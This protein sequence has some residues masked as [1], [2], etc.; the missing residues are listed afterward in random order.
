[1]TSIAKKD[2]KK[3]FGLDDRKP[4]YFFSS[5]NQLEKAA[6]KAPQIHALRRAFEQLEIN[7]V[8][9]QDRVGPF[10]GLQPVIYFRQVDNIDPNSIL[11]LHR[12]FW[13]QGIAPI[14]VVI[15]PNDVHIY[16]GLL[17]PT[18]TLIQ[19]RRSPGLVETLERV[20]DQLRSFLLSV[21]SGEY[22]HIHRHSFDPRQRVDRDL[23]HNLRVTRQALGQIQPV[24]LASPT[25][26]TLLCRLVFTCYL[27]DRG[28]IDEAYL[29]T[30]DIQDADHLRDILARKPR[31]EAKA[32]LYRLF[33]QLASDFNGDLF[34]A[35]LEEE[36]R[37]IRVEHLE[38]LDQFFHGAK[39]RSG[40][41]AFWP[42]DF[43]FIP[44]ETISAIYEHFLKAAGKE[45]KKETGAF[46]TPR[47][48][49]EFVLD[50]ALEGETSLLDK[51][52][53]D[54]ACGSGIFLVGLFN[55][56]AEE[57][58]LKNPEAYYDQRANGLMNVLRTNLYG[59]D[60][61]HSACQITAFSL[62]LA[63]LDQLSPP[64]IRK[65]LGTWDRLPHLV[66]ASG[67]P[68]AHLSAGT[69]RCADFFAEA[70]TLP[71]KVNIIIGNPP[72]G[73]VKDGNTAAV[74]WCAERKLPL[75]DRQMATAFIWKAPSHLEDS[76]RVCFVLPHGTLFNHNDTAMRFQQSLFRTHAVDRV[77]NLTDFQFFLFAESRAPALVIRYCKEKPANGAH[78]IDYWVPKTDWA[79]T[80]AEI[81]SILPQDRSRVAV[82]EVLDSLKRNDGP[83]IWKTKSWATPRDWRLLDRLS[84]MP[85]LR[86]IVSQSGRGPAKRWLIAE[87][88]QPLG[89]NDDLIKAQT[90]NLP[91]QLFIKATARQVNLFLLEG[92]CEKRS[93]A[94]VKVRLRS[95][96]STEV[97]KAPHVLVAKGFSHVAFA[98]F[99]V[100][101]RHALRGI[102]GPPSDRDLLIFLTACLRSDVARY[103]LF[104]TSSNWGV[105]R[106]EVHVE[107]LLR[108]PFPLPDDTHNPERAHA[109]V[110]EIAAAVVGAAD[111]ASRDLSNRE[112]IVRSTQEKLNKLIDEYF[113]IDDIERM[114]I[115]D[116]ARIII[117]SVRPSRG[118]LDVPTIK[119]SNAALRDSYTH[120]LCNRLN[121]WAKQ[122]YQIHA[123]PVANALIGIGMV[124]LQK[125]KR[126]EQP[127]QLHATDN[128]LLKVL[129]HLQ[130]TVAKDY[131]PFAL[132]RGLKVFYEDLLYITKPLGQRFWTNTAAL[133]DADEIAAT[134]TIRSIREGA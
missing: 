102:H 2:W 127:I 123:K 111:E 44:I 119:H 21:E 121:G 78:L 61:N 20:Q 124:V 51:R 65:L 64:D 42:Y 101:F 24:E 72:W 35:N 75:P 69:I 68:S 38:I 133:N 107:E 7:G 130:R 91:S 56:L 106:A 10:E 128:E 125:T 134:I 87:G 25:L 58:K 17:P 81:V 103:F 59:V 66:F 57:W 85:R 118:K 108:L 23:L 67:K 13:N 109:I 116:T 15:A 6:A 80:Q 114:I 18:S 63:F 92:D 48:L 30:L 22:F 50:M 131:G 98:D 79:I 94:Q 52:F 132:L 77:I 4:P 112:D 71:Q 37:Q 31:T 86:D 45:H 110:R 126:G 53:L 16:S 97:F 104:H 41:Q 95:N 96:K 43:S 36:C 49:A 60:S 46:Y 26:D 122:G 39:V 40:Q 83:L 105:S 14:L 28:I 129:D 47:L 73:S 99:D 8:L 93:S 90:L 88:F 1:M 120:L 19:S 55:R 113:D 84:L 117:P 12:A 32:D 54:P 9:C 70:A 33:N 11:S 82:R 5:I 76:G 29:K 3:D 74:R 62:Y 100:S 27:F 89:E 115:T 34:R